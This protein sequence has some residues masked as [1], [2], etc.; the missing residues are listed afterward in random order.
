MQFEENP[1]KYC[2]L[3]PVQIDNSVP[4]FILLYCALAPAIY[5]RQQEAEGFAVYESAAGALQVTIER[6]H[7]GKTFKGVDMIHCS[8]TPPIMC[9]NLMPH[10]IATK[11]FPSFN[12]ILAALLLA[13]FSVMTL[14]STSVG[15][16]TCCSLDFFDH[17]SLVAVSVTQV[18]KVYLPALGE[19][20]GL[21][22]INHPRQVHVAPA[23]PIAIKNAIADKPKN[24]HH[25]ILP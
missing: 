3:L 22:H 21:E 7:Y 5:L 25:E 9:I 8:L 19:V 1:R 15:G 16:N 11:G 24:G 18:D 13:S 10:R 6:A 17:L 2:F 20:V 4:F 12:V 23:N 14:S